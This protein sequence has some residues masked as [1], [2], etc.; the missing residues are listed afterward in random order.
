M[1]VMIVD[2]NADFRLVMAEYLQEG[3]NA[4]AERAIREGQIAPASLE[5][6]EWDP[7]ARGVPS[8][9]DGLRHV[10]DAILIDSNIDPADPVQWLEALREEFRPMPPVVM[11]TSGRDADNLIVRAMKLGV[12]GTLPRLELTPARLYAELADAVLERERQVSIEDSLRT[13]KYPSAPAP[14]RSAAGAHLPSI[15]GYTLI[16]L[17]GQGGT[18]LVYRARRE[19]DGLELVLKVLQPELMGETAVVERFM[20]EFSLIQKIQSAYV[21]RIFDLNYDNGAAYLAMEYFGAG[22]LRE[23]MKAGFKPL[24]ALK[25]FAQIARA[26]DAIHGA[27]V[28]HRDLKPHNIMFRDRHHLAIVDFGGA[29]AMGEESGITRVGQVVGTPNYMSPEQILGQALDERSDLYSLGVILHQ[30]LT[31][32]T[33]FQASSAAE[34]MDMHVNSPVPRLPPNLSGFQNL[35]SRLVAKRREDRFASARDL[36]AYIVS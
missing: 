10:Y 31:G 17:I 26:L 22:D 7:V 27:G 9:A 8:S 23:R 21:T 12:V 29:K 2:E 3:L 25:L 14:A 24:Q 5:V 4:A 15:P 34:L 11:L 19:S 1:R 35:L 32:R 13:G 36:Y 30:L 20:Q 28:V 18:A 33:L 6:R 16:E